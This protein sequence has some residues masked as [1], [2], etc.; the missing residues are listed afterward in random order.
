VYI[1]AKRTLLSASMVLL[2]LLNNTNIAFAEPNS[3]ETQ[4]IQDNKVKY[5]Q[6]DEDVL[7][8]DTE[9]AK[10]NIE[11]EALNSKL[12]ENNSEI[13]D[14]ENEITTINHKIEEAKLE[15]EDKQKNIDGRVRSMYKSNM[16]TDMI[17]YLI[18][19]ENIFDMFDR[20]QTMSK[21]ISVDKEMIL[22]VNEK[23]ESLDKDANEIQKKQD[24][25]LQLKK[26]IETNLNEVNN[27]K[28]NQQKLLD[29]L[30]SRKDEIMAI[31]EANEENLVSYP[32]SIINSDSSSIS[33]IQNA[34]NT[35]Q[36]MLPQLNSDYVIDL[37]NAAIDSGNYIIS[38]SESDQATSNS[39]GNSSE[40]L[41]TYSMIA[42]AYTGHGLT[43]MGLKPVRD[44]NGLSTVAVDPSVIPLGSK[45]YVEGYGYAIASDTGGAIKGNKID[46]Y[47]N[48]NEECFAFG[49]RTVTVNVIAYPGQW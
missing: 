12:D 14:T 38:L 25:L 36:Y 11:I 2:L 30:N 13:Q 26:S 27:K 8:L 48:S 21:I 5:E 44:P 39:V 28:E 18:T 42:T 7:K 17:V 46:V 3:S 31:I 10:L 34:I 16:A 33:E 43:I 29:E 47:M 49:R 45:V 1:L 19:S 40:Y 15:I 20:V 22:E 37:V 4:V 41:S 9:I 35:L 6:L 23:R 24:N 32:L